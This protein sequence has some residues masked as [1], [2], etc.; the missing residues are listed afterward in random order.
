MKKLCQSGN[1]PAAYTGNFRAFTRKID[2]LFDE[3]SD[4][5]NKR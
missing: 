4:K 2:G 1:L 3:K 5:K